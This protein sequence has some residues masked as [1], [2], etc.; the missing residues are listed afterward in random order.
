MYLDNL[1]RFFSYTPLF[2]LAILAGIIFIFDSLLFR[3]GSWIFILFL[4]SFS[5]LL[6][7]QIVIGLNRELVVRCVAVFL[8]ALVPR[9]MVFRTFPRLE[10]LFSG[11]EGWYVG[12]GLW[13]S[14]HFDWFFYPTRNHWFEMFLKCGGINPE[15]PQ[16]VKLFFATAIYL[17]P[18]WSPIHASRLVSVVL[19]SLSCVILFLVVRKFYGEKVGLLS[20]CY[21]AF[22]PSY[23]LVSCQGLLDP[24]ALFFLVLSVYFLVKLPGEPVY[25]AYSAVMWGLSC[26]S[27]IGLSFLFFPVFLAFFLREF[28]VKHSLTR[29]L[30]FFVLIAFVSYTVSSPYFWINPFSRHPEMIMRY[31]S[32]M[33]TSSINQPSFGF[34]LTVY[35]Y[36]GA[37]WDG[38]LSLI[39]L[40]PLPL[41][42]CLSKPWRGISTPDLLMAMWAFPYLAFYILITY[43]TPHHLTY[44]YP[45][46]PAFS[47]LLVQSLNSIQR[48]L[49]SA[50]IVKD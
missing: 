12:S 21:L 26:G 2:L 28:G 41:W 18:S 7:F 44:L 27:R 23:F 32:Q 38:I 43:S 16:L 6:V 47:V 10:A 48:S 39:T 42:V 19:S 1:N 14:Q 13:L 24:G 29:L 46:I 50:T 25:L 4:F 30:P 37:P 34:L 35:G 8:V 3:F 49:I 5:I 17:L 31:T 33:N 11:E 9:L 40:L 20:A 36:I 15:H 45:G 22:E